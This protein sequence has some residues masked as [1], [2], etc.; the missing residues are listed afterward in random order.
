VAVVGF[1]PLVRRE[2][3]VGWATAVVLGLDVYVG[4]SVVDWWAGEAFGARRFVSYT[5]LFALGLAALFSTACFRERSLL[6][7]WMAVCLIAYNLLF[8]LQYQLFMRGFRELAPYPTTVRQV[9][10]DRLVLP[11]HLLRLWLTR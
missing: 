4:A 10:L 3:S 1:Y 5:V 11:W 8:L 7:R 2:A 9:L 6:V